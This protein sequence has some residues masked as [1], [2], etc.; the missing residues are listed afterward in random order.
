M[1]HLTGRFLVLAAGMGIAEKRL[2]LYDW[3]YTA[4]GP[5]WKNQA[6]PVE[7]YLTQKQ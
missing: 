4:T 6:G 3:L 7:A 1:E 2:N 5:A